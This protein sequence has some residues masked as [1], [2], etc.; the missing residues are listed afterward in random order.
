[1]FGNKSLTALGLTNRP[2]SPS[3][4]ITVSDTAPPRATASAVPFV[5]TSPDLPAVAAYFTRPPPYFNALVTGNVGAA[6]DKIV[7]AI[8]SPPDKSMSGLDSANLLLPIIAPSVT[9][10]PSSWYIFLPAWS[11]TLLNP[12]LSNSGF[13][14]NTFSYLYSVT[15]PSA[16]FTGMYRS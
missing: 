6:I 11:I 13:G 9:K 2:S 16:S 1:M 10:P 8:S 7:E 3:P 5:P 14:I 12:E 4:D 15:L